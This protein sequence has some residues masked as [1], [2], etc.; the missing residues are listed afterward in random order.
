MNVVLNFLNTMYPVYIVT[1]LYIVQAAQQIYVG[2]PNM[3]LVFMGY[4]IANLGIIGTMQYMGA[5]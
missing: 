3:A 1:A 5:S 4:V 2:Q